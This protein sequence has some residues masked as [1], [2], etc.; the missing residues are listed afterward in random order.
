MTLGDSLNS[1]N[2]SSRYR[3]VVSENPS[4]FIFLQS[5][6]FG[7]FL[8]R[9]AYKRMSIP[10][11]IPVSSTHR[12]NV[13]VCVWSQLLRGDNRVGW[14][15]SGRPLCSQFSLRHLYRSGA[16][17]Q[18]C[19]PPQVRKITHTSTDTHSEKDF[20]ERFAHF[21]CLF[22]LFVSADGISLSLKTTLKVGRHWFPFSCEN[23]E[24]GAKSIPIILFLI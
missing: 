21:E 17:Q 14:L 3:V 6:M 19:G 18:G 23:T 12:R 5:E 9:W 15:R 24:R 8:L 4:H 11:L 10:A 7:L 20:V 16:R 22:S 13:W 1:S 2:N